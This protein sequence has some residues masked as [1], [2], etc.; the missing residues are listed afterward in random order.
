MEELVSQHAAGDV[1]PVVL[2]GCVTAEKGDDGEAGRGV[3]GSHEAVV[4]DVK[5]PARV[6]PDDESCQSRKRR[7]RGPRESAVAFGAGP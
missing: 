2:V 6:A 1:A 5:P 7:G 3:D 4:R